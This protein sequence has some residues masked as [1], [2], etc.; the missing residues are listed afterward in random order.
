[1]TDPAAAPRV[2]PEAP[3]AREA[4]R[5]PITGTPLVEVVG[6]DG[7]LALENTSTERVLRYPVR[8]GVPVLLPHEAIE[9]P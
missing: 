2:L 7:A 8:D 5:C 4:L 9:R 6:Q 1:M 3:W